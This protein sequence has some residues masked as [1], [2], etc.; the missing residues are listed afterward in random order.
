MRLRVND[1]VHAVA[2]E[3]HEVLVD[4]LRERLGLTGAKQACG[5]D[6]CGGWVAVHPLVND[7][8]AVRRP[9]TSHRAVSTR[10]HHPNPAAAQWHSTLARHVG[11]LRLL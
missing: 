6:D 3:P 1:Q 2:V 7:A 9:E 10:R 4:T 11:Q 5:I 8:P